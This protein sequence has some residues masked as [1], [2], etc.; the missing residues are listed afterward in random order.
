MLD[1]LE[2]LIHWQV[3]QECESDDSESQTMHW[4]F[5]LESCGLRFK[6]DMKMVSGIIYFHQILLAKSFV[7]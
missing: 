4:T 5:G 3:E 2:I 1:R 7:G 6:F